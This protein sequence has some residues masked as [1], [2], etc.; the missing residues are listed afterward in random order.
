LD[1]NSNPGGSLR[2][3]RVCDC[4]GYALTC[5]FASFSYQSG[6]HPLLPRHS[7]ACIFKSRS[8]LESQPISQRANGARHCGVAFPRWAIPAAAPRVCFGWL[9]SR[10][11]LGVAAFR[12]APS[13]AASTATAT[14]TN[15]GGQIG[16]STGTGSHL[17]PQPAGSAGTPGSG[18]VR[19]V[20]SPLRTRRS[21]H[22]P[23][24][25]TC[26]PLT[27]SAHPVHRR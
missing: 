15:P 3:C 24:P 7:H 6:R 12:P 1:R 14:A 4:N 18:S 17:T 2:G 22:S 20:A 10:G 27:G 13:A 23:S 16:C 9:P 19:T 25:R 5:C 21:S 11:L 26:H 8:K